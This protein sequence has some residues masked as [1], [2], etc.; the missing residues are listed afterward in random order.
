MTPDLLLAGPRG[1]RLCLELAQPPAEDAS[2]AAREL[3]E[4]LFY[5]AHHA[6]PG[7]GTSRSIFGWGVPD[8]LPE[9]RTADVARLIDARAVPELSPARLLQ[10][11]G[12]TVD[13][14][15]YWQEPDGEDILAASP[16]VAGALAPVAGRVVASPHVA[17]W[18]APVRRADQWTVTFVEP[19][20]RSP[21][22]WSGLS[23][24]ERLAR[25]SAE[26]RV[27]EDRARRQRPRDPR[28]SW[29]GEW[30]SAPVRRVVSTTCRAEHGGPLGLRLVED[31]LGWDR[32]TVRRV[33]VPADA[34]VYEVD[35]PDA[36]TAL[37]R[38]HPFDVSASRRHD[39][40]RATGEDRTWVLPDWQRV[41]ENFDA[42][43]VT[44]SGYL[45]T[46]GRALPLGDGRHTVLAGWDPDATIW[47]TDLPGTGTAEETWVRADDGEWSRR[48]P[49]PTT[50]G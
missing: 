24:A 23:A 48:Q 49:G 7:A 18:T 8:P 50:A 10:G 16:E 44:V 36:W 40:F 34:R 21:E 26:E 29:S 6:D 22:A 19:D 41:A 38:R 20:E 11:L 27:A 37:C 14:A 1:R 13:S 2:D 15:R 3:R 32:A 9:P 35:E 5:A 28:A 43:H 42:V 12:A 46:A 33:D 39:W 45:T 17:W 31:E 25:W 4:A 30:W 47:L